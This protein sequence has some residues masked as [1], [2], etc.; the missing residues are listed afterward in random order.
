MEDF[1]QAL[2]VVGSVKLSA[3]NYGVL[4]HAVCRRLRR[5]ISA[6]VTSTEGCLKVCGSCDHNQEVNDCLHDRTAKEL[7]SCREVLQC[8]TFLCRC[9]IVGRLQPSK[10][11]HF[12]CGSVCSKSGTIEHRQP[13]SFKHIVRRINESIRLVTVSLL[14]GEQNGTIVTFHLLILVNLRK[15]RKC[16]S[17]IGCV[18]HI[19]SGSIEF[20]CVICFHEAVVRRSICFYHIRLICLNNRMICPIVQ[21][22]CTC[23]SVSCNVLVIFI[24]SDGCNSSR[25]T[26]YVHVFHEPPHRLRRK[27][28]VNLV[29]CLLVG[30]INFFSNFHLLLSSLFVDYLNV[31][32]TVINAN[33]AFLFCCIVTKFI[34]ILCQ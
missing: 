15:P 14:H 31:N 10:T 4:L 20:L 33:F 32:Q 28:I 12:R 23:T 2:T 18:R 24:K 3:A 29:L 7:C 30:Y 21:R 11:Y 9:R 27:Q 17:I 34:C 6:T 25:R 13:H 16:S 1:I 19:R 22:D 26:L 5:V 8:C